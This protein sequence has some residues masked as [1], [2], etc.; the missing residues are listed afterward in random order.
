MPAELHPKLVFED[1]ETP[2]LG[3]L[4]G[5]IGALSSAGVLTPDDELERWVRD[6]GNMPMPDAESGREDTQPDLYSDD[7]MA[8]EGAEGSEQVLNSYASTRELP[9]SVRDRIP[10]VEGKAIWLR[11]FNETEKDTK[12]ESRAASEAWASLERAGYQKTKE[13]I[14]EKIIRNSEAKG[15]DDVI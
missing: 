5:A 2:D 9:D 15:V 11:A 6:F 7:L 13:G 4:A 8:G 3:E 14:Y 12:D 1:I 10:S